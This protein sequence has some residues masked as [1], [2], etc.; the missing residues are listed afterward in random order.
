MD[1]KITKYRELTHNMNV[2]IHTINEDFNKEMISKDGLTAIDNL[3][4]INREY[5]KLCKEIKDNPYNYKESDINIVNR[6]MMVYKNMI[7]NAKKISIYYYNQKV[8]ELNRRLNIIKINANSN[9]DFDKTELDN[10][11]VPEYNDK[12][13]SNY[14][15]KVNLDFDGL[16]LISDEMSKVERK[17]SIAREFDKLIKMDYIENFVLERIENN[18]NNYGIDKSVTKVSIEN[19]IFWV[20]YELDSLRKTDLDDYHPDRI[21]YIEGKLEFLRNK[22]SKKKIG[23]NEN[24]QE[25]HLLKEKV[26]LFYREVYEYRVRIQEKFEV[27]ADDKIKEIRNKLIFLRGEY[28]KL[29][30]SIKN[31]K[32]LNDSMLASFNKVENEIREFIKDSKRIL[33]MKEETP[34]P[35]KKEETKV[36]T[37]TTD[38][39][40]MT[41][42]YIEE[43]E[44]QEVDDKQENNSEEENEEDEYEMVSEPSEETID[45]GYEVVDTR[46]GEEVYKKFKKQVLISASLATVALLIPA[47]SSYILP[48]IL[49]Q[50]LALAYAH[51]IMNKI[52]NII[53]KS[54]GAKKDKSGTW[55]NNRGQPITKMSSLS[56]LLKSLVIN[57][58]GKSAIVT[59]IANTIK[60]IGELMP[61]T[62]NPYSDREIVEEIDIETLYQ[63]YIDSGKGFREFCNSQ[64]LSEEDVGILA[65]YVIENAQKVASGRSK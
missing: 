56:G 37:I 25:Y 57:G 40:D 43:E 34:L 14:Q 3:E 60:K 13:L 23:K 26:E 10:I 24:N 64:S 58:V 32:V 5:L 29:P 22:L 9:P 30:D 65:S 17:L 33:N 35:V 18:I 21:T 46:S 47:L 6:D 8:Y 4:K 63:M 42:Y 48:A 19:D 41:D 1:D 16:N 31:D 54:I 55:R 11:K 7:L 12:V 52:N 28:S 45:E 53:G 38:D 62:D 20:G 61:T 44:K 59:S 51:P 49:V 15:D 50:N 39:I 27:I 36:E 2:L